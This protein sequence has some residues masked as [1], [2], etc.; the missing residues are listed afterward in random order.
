V[1]ALFVRDQKQTAE[2]KTRPLTDTFA[3]TSLV[4]QQ[5]CRIGR[6]RLEIS[7]LK[8]LCSLRFLLF[9]S[10]DLTRN[11]KSKIENRNFLDPLLTILPSMI[12]QTSAYIFAPIFLPY[13]F[14]FRL[15][16]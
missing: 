13:S 7:N 5:L 12:L 15:C 6:A 11:R 8:C 14:A 10:D 2:P 3:K 4:L 16:G 9:P 1:A